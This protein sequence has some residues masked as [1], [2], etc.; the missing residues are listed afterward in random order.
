V[1][2]LVLHGDG[3]ATVPFA[4]S[5]ARTHAAI[6]GSELVVVPGGP[7]GFNVSHAAEF[8]QA[9]LRFLER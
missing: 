3:D 1:P 7:H 8:N 9:L 2:T 4:G 6:P 5:G